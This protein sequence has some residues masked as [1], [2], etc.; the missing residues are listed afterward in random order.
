MQAVV[1]DVERVANGGISALPLKRDPDVYKARNSS[2]REAAEALAAHF[3]KEPPP[4]VR[5]S[6]GDF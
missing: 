1:D 6:P 3:G 4:T 2:G 5:Y